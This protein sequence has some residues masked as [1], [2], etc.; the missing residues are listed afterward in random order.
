VVGVVEGIVKEL[1][2]MLSEL[3]LVLERSRSRG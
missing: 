3:E 2:R 1:K